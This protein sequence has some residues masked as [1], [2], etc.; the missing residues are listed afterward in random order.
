[1]NE[2]IRVVL[3]LLVAYYAN[4]LQVV[5]APSTS[6]PYMLWGQS[7]SKVIS[8]SCAIVE[9]RQS[10]GNHWCRLG[11]LILEIF[12]QLQS[13]VNLVCQNSAAG[14]HPSLISSSTAGPWTLWLSVISILMSCN[15]KEEKT[16][17]PCLS[18]S[19]LSIPYSSYFVL[20]TL[21]YLSM[22]CLSIPYFPYLTFACSVALT[23]PKLYFSRAGLE[24]PK[25]RYL[26]GLLHTSK[27]MEWMCISFII[28]SPFITLFP[29]LIWPQ[30][31]CS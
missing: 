9:N 29:Y 26:V 20:L 23:F 14:R 10:W 12:P 8:R 28:P 13:Q 15:P 5:G 1:M 25:S 6:V 24:V 31:V 19:F 30:L 3:V 17:L 22:P 4:L 2:C 21:S 18:W 16:R 11:K 27:Y 7:W